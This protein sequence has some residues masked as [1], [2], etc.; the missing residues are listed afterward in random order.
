M[1][2]SGLFEC[3]MPLPFQ[4]VVHVVVF[5]NEFRQFLRHRRLLPRFLLKQ[6]LVGLLSRNQRFYVL[7]KLLYLLLELL[8]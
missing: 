5:G 8:Y 3:E 7:A 6:P 1:A 2:V 4:T